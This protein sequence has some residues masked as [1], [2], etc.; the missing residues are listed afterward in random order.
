M[1]VLPRASSVTLLEALFDDALE[2]AGRLFAAFGSFWRKPS[3]SS[4]LP[5]R[6]ESGNLTYLRVQAQMLR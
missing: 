6:A 5:Q 4:Q 2:A 3:G 1:L